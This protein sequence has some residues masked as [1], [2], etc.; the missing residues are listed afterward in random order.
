MKTAATTDPLTKLES[1]GLNNM[2][3]ISKSGVPFYPGQ[4]P[5]VSNPSFYAP[6]NYNGKTG[7]N[8]AANVSTATPALNGRFVSP[9]RWNKP[10]LMQAKSVTDNTPIAPDGISATSFPSPD[11][12]LVAKD[13]SDTHLLN[14]PPPSTGTTAIV[15]RYAYIIYN[16]GGLLDAN[17]AGYPSFVTNTALPTSSPAITD[18]TTYKGALSYADLTQLLSFSTELQAATSPTSGP[19]TGLLTQAQVDQLVGWRN[20]VS[21]SASGSLGT[22]TFPSNANTAVDFLSW[23][24]L[25]PSRFLTAKNTFP[26]APATPS[27]N[28]DHLFISRQ[29]LIQFVM[30]GMSPN[31]TDSTTLQ[32]Q[33]AALQCLGTFSRTLNQPSIWP[34]PNRAKVKLKPSTASGNTYMADST[35]PGGNFAYSSDGSLSD[36]YN[37]VFRNIRVANPFP[38]NDGTTAV[39]GEPLVKKRFALSRVAWIT[40]EGPSAKAADEATLVNEYVSRGMYKADAQSLLDEGTAQNILK[41]FGLQWTRGPGTNGIGGYWTYNNG[42]T[43]G[44]A[45]LIGSLYDPT[46]PSTSRD[47]VSANREPD[48]FELLKAGINVGAIG[49]DWGGIGTNGYQGVQDSSI[50]PQI[51]AIGANIIDEASVTQFPTTIRYY[52]ASGD[53]RTVY[54]KTDLPYNNGDVTFAYVAQAPTTL[55]SSA[56]APTASATSIDNNNSGNNLLGAGY[57]PAAAGTGVLMMAPSIWNPYDVDSPQVSPGLAPTQLRIVMGDPIQTFDSTPG[58]PPQ[59]AWLLSSPNAYNFDVDATFDK[60]QE[61]PLWLP[62]AGYNFQSYMDNTTTNPPTITYPTVYWKQGANA[63]WTSEESTALLFNNV[64]PSDVTTRSLYREPTLLM[65]SSTAQATNYPPDNVMALRMGTQHHI[66]TMNPSKWGSGIPE[67]LSGQIY[68]GELLGTFPLRFTVAGNNTDPTNPDPTPFY[69]YTNDQVGLHPAAKLATWRMEFLPPGVSDAPGNWIPYQEKMVDGSPDALAVPSKPQSGTGAA[70]Y[71]LTPNDVS[72]TGGSGRSFFYG[73]TSGDAMRATGMTTACEVPFDPRTDRWATVWDMPTTRFL[74]GIYS[75]SSTGRLVLGPTMSPAASPPPTMMMETLRSNG[76]A[77]GGSHS[78]TIPG[79]H[80]DGGPYPLG[81][82]PQPGIISQNLFTTP[83]STSYGAG[84]YCYGADYVTRRGSGGDN[85]VYAPSTATFGLPLATSTGNFNSGSPSSGDTYSNRPIILHRP[86]RTVA[87]LGYVFSDTPWLNLDLNNPESG[88]SG[89]L[90]LFCVNEDTRSDALMAGKLDL[91]TRK[92]SVLTA[93]MY[94]AYREIASPAD[95]RLNTFTPPSQGT[96]PGTA[97]AV[98]EATAMATKLIKRTTSVYIQQG[99]LANISDLVGHFVP[100]FGVYNGSPTGNPSAAAQNF[101]AFDGFSSDIATSPTP[102]A[103]QDIVQRFREAPI[104][105][106]S[107]GGQAGTWNLMIDIIA[108][109]GRYPANTTKLQQFSVEG[110]RRYWVHV[111]IDRQTGQVIDQQLEQVN[112]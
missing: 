80:R 105:A 74:N 54:G 78:T 7:P 59:P 34:D 85:S 91:N 22:Y 98:S 27:G 32:H 3:K 57:Y 110:E 35:L 10:L 99:P 4:I 45:T 58:W 82:G 53:F 46:S 95:T 1:D 90:D 24:T 31:A 39:V 97:E 29:Q 9:A 2:L 23:S 52:F 81:N 20:T 25:N 11:W 68:T 111:A 15:G 92:P 79:W 63:P 18:Q 72:A 67:A 71:L 93:M 70:P 43:S 26:G 77:G 19:Y 36:I 94:N 48:F 17:V 21:A 83:L 76:T 49:K 87:E 6:T 69:I 5:N 112:E 62:P 14:Q 89:L 108:Q 44:G 65:R 104:R 109:I 40:Y 51:L 33:Q 42:I 38:R 60:T 103:F 55:P 100:S 64:N 41:Y 66:A 75:V 61:P 30:N 88:F 96:A 16:E 8:R 28:S 84:F 86:Y 13:G 107:S 50:M 106:L 73:N 101:Q 56:G 37:P 12:I 102:T 47:V